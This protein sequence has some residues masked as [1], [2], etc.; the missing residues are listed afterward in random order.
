MK[1]ANRY[2]FQKLP[3]KNLE[4][5]KEIIQLE[6]YLESESFFLYNEADTN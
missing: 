1:T 6:I 5:S 3:I 4:K 2:P